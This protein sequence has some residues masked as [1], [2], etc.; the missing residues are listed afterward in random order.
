MRRNVTQARV[1]AA[2]LL[3]ASLGMGGVDMRAVEAP[4]HG[5]VT[6]LGESEKALLQGR[7]DEAIAGLRGVLQT[8]PESGEAHLLLCRAYYAEEMADAAVT[9]CESALGHLGQ[10][11]QAQDWMG[12]AYGLKAGHSNP[13]QGYKLA[14]RVKTAFEAAVQ[15]NSSNGAAVNDLGEYYVSAPSILGGGVDRATEL[16]NR[17]HGQLPQESH[18]ILAMAAEKERDYATAEREY[19]AAV[20]VAGHADAWTD[21]GHFYYRQNHTEMALEALHKALAADRLHDASLVDVASILIKM[22]REPETA[23]RALA[24]YLGSSVKTDD[25]PAFKAYVE[26]GKLKQSL[27]DKAGAEMAYQSALGL[28]KDIEPARKAIQHV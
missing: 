16:A 3:A 12:R 25:A 4:K 17:V 28:A 1:F 9:E 2:A 20:S 23:E 19:R 24:D 18:R 15:L 13:I 21:L 14:G 27:G 10:D 26:L 6:P 11:S 8:N 22:K 7:N 5:L